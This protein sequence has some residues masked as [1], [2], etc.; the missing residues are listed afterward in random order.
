LTNCWSSPTATAATADPVTE[1]SPPITT[2]MNA[3][4]SN[5]AP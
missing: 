3:K 1:P 2:T 5:E 4:I